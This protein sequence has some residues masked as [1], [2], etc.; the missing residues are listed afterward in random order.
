MGVILGLSMS[1]R[2]FCGNRASDQGLPTRELK[3]GQKMSG[4][5]TP[6]YPSRGAF[7]AGVLDELCVQIR[8]DL[9]DRAEALAVLV[10]APR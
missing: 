1:Y 3:A 10:G 9:A 7:I 2:A 6:C 8:A 4:V 5:Y